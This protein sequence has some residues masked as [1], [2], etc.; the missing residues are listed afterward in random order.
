MATRKKDAMEKIN[1]SLERLREIH[2]FLSD[3]KDG[4]FVGKTDI[5]TMMIICAIAQEPMVIF[6]EPG[7]AKSALIS[8]FCDLL[9]FAEG[10]YFKYLLTSFTEPDELLGVVDIKAYMD[11]KEFKRVGTSGI[12]HA[13]IVFLDEVFR[14]NSAILNTLLSIIN[15]RIYYEGGIV[16]RARTQVVYGASNDAPTSVDLTAFYARFPIR[17]RSDRVSEEYPLELLSK[18]W[19]LE[20][21]DTHT[22]APISQP[23]DLENCQHWLRSYWLRKEI[24][25][26]EDS[27]LAAIKRIYFEIVRMM[28][29]HKEQFR[30]DDRKAVKLFKLIVAHAMFFNG[31]TCVPGLNDIWSVLRYTWENPETV[32]LAIDNVTQYVLEANERYSVRQSDSETGLELPP[33]PE[34]LRFQSVSSEIAI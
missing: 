6:G 34:K 19:H 24:W 10:D 23:E 7:T 5:V 32:R 9:G 30:I 1:D 3:A 11:D 16:K 22:L 17:M 20:M 2:R 14:A 8:I 33:L 27:G 18:G 13:K 15:E 4:M 21:V 29:G 26:D 28:N 31:P 12:Q 25:E